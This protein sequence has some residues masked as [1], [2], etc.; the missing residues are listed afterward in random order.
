MV[1]LLHRHPA[2]VVPEQRMEV[3]HGW[4]DDFVVLPFDGVTLLVSIAVLAGR[5]VLLLVTSELG[6]RILQAV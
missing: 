2:L 5:L 6:L 1:I 4:R 3:T